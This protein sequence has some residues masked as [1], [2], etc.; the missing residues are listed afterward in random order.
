MKKCSRCG[1]EQPL[2]QFHKRSSRKSGYASHCKVCDSNRTKTWREDNPEIALARFTRWK[3]ANPEKAIVRVKLWKI[4]NPE[5]VRDSDRSKSRRRRAQINATKEKYT[6]AQ[7]IDT[8][9]TDCHLCG[10][11]IDFNAPRHPQFEGWEMGLQIDH[12]LPLSRK[13]ADNLANVR[14]SHAQCNIRKNN[15]IK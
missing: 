6:E 12:V 13:G 1:I 9:G 11:P 7:V 15:S 3:Q 5:K 14:P 10:K 2:S 4:A 8:Y